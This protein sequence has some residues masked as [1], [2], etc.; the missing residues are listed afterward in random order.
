MHCVAPAGK[1]LTREADEAAAAAAAEEE[2]KKSGGMAGA[3][4]SRTR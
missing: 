1:A 2:R 4:K 3:F